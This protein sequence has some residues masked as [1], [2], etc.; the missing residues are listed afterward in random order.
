MTPVGVIDPGIDMSRTNES[1]TIRPPPS[2]ATPEK[3]SRAARTP[4]SLDVEATVNRT[5]SSD[6]VTE[7]QAPAKASGDV[8][9]ARGADGPEAQAIVVHAATIIMQR[10]IRSPC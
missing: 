2:Q 3:V 8:A 4:L 6:D 10:I 9:G 1:P 5:N 7:R